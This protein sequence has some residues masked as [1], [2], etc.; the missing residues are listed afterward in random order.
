MSDE[1]KK[2]PKT[3]SDLIKQDEINKQNEKNK[4]LPLPLGDD[5]LNSFDKDGNMYIKLTMDDSAL[6]VR[7][8]GTVDM[9]S[10]DLEKS[11]DG[12]VGDVEDLNKTFS[13]VLALASAIENED[14]YN[15]IF[16]NLN[17]TLMQR[18]EQIPSDIKD[19]IVEQRDETE[20]NRT[21]S[22][23]AEKQK[24]VDEFRKR[25][26]KYKEKFLDDEKRK[27]MDDLA[28]EADFREQYSDDFD[29]PEPKEP[30][31]EDFMM[32]QLDEHMQN[33]ERKSK[34]KMKKRKRNPLAKLIGVD[35]NPYD[36]TLVEK[37]GK[38]RLDYPPKD[39][40]ED[41]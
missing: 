40:G 25:M 15:R 5:K 1:E 22:D 39:E 20:R 2:K 34:P 29:A 6:V 41:E 32:E 17:M 35:W 37:K 26:N 38:W 13:L 18:W 24:R 7:A 33:M 14:L 31:N 27:L 19:G 9:I 8:D 4:N 28:A 16:H 30:V 3:P 11:Q 21:A 12:Y 10:H 23:R 36:K